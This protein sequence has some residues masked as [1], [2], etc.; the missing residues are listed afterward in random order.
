MRIVIDLA[1]QQLTLI[2]ALGVVL[3]QFPVSTAL[4]GAGEQG[5]SYQTPR[6]RHAIRAMIGANAPIGAVFRSRRLTGEVYSAELASA[7]PERDWILTRIIWLTGRVPGF[8]R[9]G[10]VDTMARYIYIHGTPDGEPMGTPASHGCIRMRNTD[11]VTLF[12]VLRPGAEVDIVAADIDW[13]VYP[14]TAAIEVEGLK[15]WSLPGPV[16]PVV[17]A[18][19]G[20]VGRVF[21]LWQQ[22]GHCEGVGGLSLGGTA[23]LQLTDQGAGQVDRLLAALAEEARSLGWRHVDMLAPSQP[24][25][26]WRLV[27]AAFTSEIGLVRRYRYVL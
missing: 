7:Q 15:A 12:E 27:S 24:A 16:S 11:L 21:A 25:Q 17:E 23:W 14:V 26:G 9:R 10:G 3:N 20:S 13:L 6:G 1:S 5:G 18:D 8:N 2:T 22:Q 4:N 19:D